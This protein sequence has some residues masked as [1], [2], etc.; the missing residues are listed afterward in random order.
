[1]QGSMFLNCFNSWL[2]FFEYPEK[3]LHRQVH[4][5]TSIQIE[6]ARPGVGVIRYRGVS[7]CSCEL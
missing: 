1:M 4:A 5:G 7:A 6:S 3:F 2:S